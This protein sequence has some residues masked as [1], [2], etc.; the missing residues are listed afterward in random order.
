MHRVTHCVVTTCSTNWSTTTSANCICRTNLNA[1]L[2]LHS[3]FGRTRII[4]VLLLWSVCLQQQFVPAEKRRKLLV[5]SVA[6]KETLLQL[7]AAHRKALQVRNESFCALLW[8]EHFRWAT[9]RR[10]LFQWPG[11]DTGTSPG[12][13]QR[14]QPSILNTQTAMQGQN[15]GLTSVNFSQKE[16]HQPSCVRRDTFQTYLRRELPGTAWLWQLRK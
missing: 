5:R 9:Q 14:A 10:R 16:P 12:W 6:L 1:Q 7:E 3:Q 4:L 13:G 8:C 2:F 15:R 11:E